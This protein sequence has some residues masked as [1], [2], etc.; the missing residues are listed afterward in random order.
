MAKWLTFCVYSSARALHYRTDSCVVELLSSA[1]G[2]EAPSAP[3][4]LGGYRLGESTV[5]SRP[6]GRIE[7]VMPAAE[8][9]I[10]SFSARVEASL[11][12]ILRRQI[13]NH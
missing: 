6:R 8:E 13:A 11:L 10:D 7:V 4:L 5:L 1:L 2:R 9:S 12:A 3:P